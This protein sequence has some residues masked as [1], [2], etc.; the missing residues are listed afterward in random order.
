PV[1]TIGIRGTKFDIVCVG[2]CGAAGAKALGQEQTNAPSAALAKVLSVVVPSANAQSAN[3][4]WVGNREGQVA[5]IYPGGTQP[6]PTGSWGFMD[7]SKAAKVDI[8]PA[9]PAGIVSDLERTPKPEDIRLPE[10]L[11]GKRAEQNAKGL[12]LAVFDN[13]NIV[14]TNNQTGEEVNLSPRTAAIITKT[15]TR[16]VKEGIPRFVNDEFNI[17]P[18]RLTK[19]GTVLPKAIPPPVQKGLACTMG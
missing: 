15:E 7:G 17:N 14:A 10:A 11:L 1:A 6:I 2:D 12:W 9:P 16:L 3:G 4:L 19:S 8:S 5:L 18:A 13:G